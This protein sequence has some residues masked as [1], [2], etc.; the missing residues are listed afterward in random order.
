MLNSDKTKLKIFENFNTDYNLPKH[1]KDDSD[2]SVSRGGSFTTNPDSWSI[3]SDG[4]THY[5]EKRSW[6]KQLGFWLTYKTTEI[7][8]NREEKKKLNPS[9]FFT[10]ISSAFEFKKFDQDKY[11]KRIDGYLSTI[12][13]AKKLG[14]VALVEKL[15]NEIELIKSE[16]LLFGIGNVKTITEEQVIHFYKKSKKGLRLDWIKNFTR[17][18][19]NKIVKQKIKI[20]NLKVFDNYVILH[21]D[22]NETAFEMTKEEKEDPIL[23]GVIRGSRKLYYIADW[24]DKYCDLTLE[25]LIDEFGKKAIKANDITVNFE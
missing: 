18:I 21:F 10:Q 17:V 2:D 11:F 14:Q 7:K 16:S 25:T 13:N 23:F 24:K 9:E 19:P 22:P 8:A 15:E 5:N 3:E 6:L 1:K 12:E 4:S 20:D